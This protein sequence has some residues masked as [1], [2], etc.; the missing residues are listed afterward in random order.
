MNR[1]NVNDAVEANLESAST[2]YEEVNQFI[3]SVAAPDSHSIIIRDEK[4]EKLI[5]K[6]KK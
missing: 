6:R 1:T 4:R 3:N 5:K 2:S